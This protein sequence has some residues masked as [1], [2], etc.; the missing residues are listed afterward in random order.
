MD[1][2][3][4]VDKA[5]LDSAIENA[6]FENSLIVGP[7]VLAPLDRVTIQDCRFDGPPETIFI[8]VPEGRKVM[9]VIGLRNTTF[10]KC[11]FRNIAIMGTPK[12]VREFR[13]GFPGPSQSPAPAPT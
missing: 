6:L 8:E 5:G 7:A 3:R 10:R 2:V 1:V 4:I 12:A 13:K 9:G 11:E